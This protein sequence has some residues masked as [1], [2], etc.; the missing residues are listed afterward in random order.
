MKV[1]IID[2]AWRGRAH[3]S[4]ILDVVFISN[5]VDKHARDELIERVTKSSSRTIWR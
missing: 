5:K 1:F 3:Y 2:D 4:P